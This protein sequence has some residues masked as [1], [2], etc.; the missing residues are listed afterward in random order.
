R[1]SDGAWISIWGRAELDDKVEHLR[2]L[3]KDNWDIW[4][5]EADKFERAVLVNVE[6][7]QIEFWEPKK[8]RFHQFADMIKARYSDSSITFDE[9]V[10]RLRV[11][12]QDLA[13]AAR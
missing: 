2:Q 12:A 4:F 1:S 3:W 7:I 11:S 10:H 5:D 8:G 9:S 6:P 13:E